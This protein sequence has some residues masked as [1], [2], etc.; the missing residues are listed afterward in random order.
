MP[1]NQ[2]GHLRLT[3]KF[4]ALFDVS[5]HSGFGAIEFWA[6]FQIDAPHMHPEMVFVSAYFIYRRSLNG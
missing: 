2:L 4:S 6:C 3:L 5:S 1:G